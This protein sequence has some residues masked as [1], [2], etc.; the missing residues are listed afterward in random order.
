LVSGVDK[1]E[2]SSRDTQFVYD[3]MMVLDL[4]SDAGRILA[5][6]QNIVMDGPKLT[7]ANWQKQ[8]YLTV[9]G[10]C[11]TS[12]G[13]PFTCGNPQGEGYYN[14]GATATFSC[15]SRVRDFSWMGS[16]GG[17]YQFDMWR[18]GEGS[19][20]R[21]RTETLVMD[22]AKRATAIYIYIDTDAIRNI[23]ILV[24]IGVLSPAV[25]IW[26]TR[27]RRRRQ[28]PPRPPGFPPVGPTGGPVRPPVGP[29][30]PPVGGPIGPTWGP[31]PPG[32]WGT[33]SPQAGQPTGGWTTTPTSPRPPGTGP[34]G[35]PSTGGPGTGGPSTGGLGTGGPGT[36]GPSTSGSGTG[37]P[38]TGAPGT[39]GRP[40][41]GPGIGGPSTSAQTGG[42]ESGAEL[43]RVTPEPEGPGLVGT[44]AA[45][46]GLGATGIGAAALARRRGNKCVWCGSK[47]KRDQ[48]TCP[49]CGVHQECQTCGT[50]LYKAS[51]VSK[52]YS[53]NPEDQGLFCDSCNTFTS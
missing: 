52:G 51:I 15:D 10:E 35:A 29:V 47:I 48:I 44:A 21:A 1:A 22:R 41:T 23:A 18:G 43:T 20:S 38:G 33:P 40:P 27:N 7:L 5:P 50:P 45:A 9:N 4:P 8:Y 49:R 24:S 34:T 16:L 30:R 12:S 37:S 6:G 53:G 19:T 36:G 31:P 26:V 14:E 42:G 46:A 39:S 3:H 17:F 28:P 13:A 32:G 25:L 11:L 2:V